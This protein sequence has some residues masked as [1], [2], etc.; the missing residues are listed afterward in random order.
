MP[1]AKAFFQDGTRPSS[2][3]LDEFDSDDIEFI[4]SKGTPGNAEIEVLDTVGVKSDAESHPNEG[5]LLKNPKS[6]VK[7][8]WVAP[9]WVAMYELMLKDGMRFPILRLIRDV[10]DNYEIA[11]S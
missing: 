7:V 3:H 11:P 5:M 9:G 2:H 10:C 4:Y 6:S 8:D 1:S